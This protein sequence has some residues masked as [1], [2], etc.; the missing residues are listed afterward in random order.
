[1]FDCSDLPQYGISS[2]GV[3]TLLSDDDD[4]SQQGLSSKDVYCDMETAGGG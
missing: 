3:Y 4:T 1:M 2:S